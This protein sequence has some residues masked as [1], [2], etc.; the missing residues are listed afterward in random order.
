M[1]HKQNELKLV[2]WGAAGSLLAVLLVIVR[3][4]LVGN[5]TFDF[6]VWNLFLAWLPLLFAA[7]AWRWWEKRPF[8]LLYT[9]LWLLFFPNAPYILTDFIHLRQR[10]GVPIWFDFLLLLAFALAGLYV[11]LLSLDWLHRLVAGEN[12]RFLGWLFVLTTLSLSSFG[13]YMGRFWRWNSWDMLLRPT[14]VLTH[15]AHTLTDPANAQHTATA[16]LLLT[17]ILLISYAFFHFPQK[18]RERETNL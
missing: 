11:G 14:A 16:T 10:G 18:A 3:W 13:V 5:F 7:M 15:L 2:L 9:T 17:V 6:M 8:S 1:L 12:G 4:L